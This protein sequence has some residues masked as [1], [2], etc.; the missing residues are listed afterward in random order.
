ME[1]QID[2]KTI[3]L[4]VAIV[5][6]VI[7]IFSFILYLTIGIPWDFYVE[8]IQNGML[9]SGTRANHACIEI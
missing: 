6:S 5:L 7:G 8:C 2:K 3:I 4:F 1:T 9:P